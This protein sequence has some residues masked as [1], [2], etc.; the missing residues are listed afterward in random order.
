MKD[1]YTK[2]LNCIIAIIRYL[3][4][5]DKMSPEFEALMEKSIVNKIIKKE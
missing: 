4:K 1:H 5:E 3:E 2:N